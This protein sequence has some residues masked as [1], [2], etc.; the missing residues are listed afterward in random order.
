MRRSRR[1]SCLIGALLAV[2]SGCGKNAPPSAGPVAKPQA[3]AGAGVPAFVSPGR[4]FALPDAAR[5]S[6]VHLEPDGTRRLIV[7]GMRL[8]ERP[9]G[10]IERGE[11]VFPASRV[12]SAR[13]LPERLGGGHLFHASTGS[14]T[15]LWRAKEWT[16]R[17]EPFANV[18][19]DVESIVPGFDRLYVF[20]RRA[21]EVIALDA[22][23]GKATDLGSLPA[24][25]SY[26]SIAVVDDW[27]AAVDVPYQGILAT[28]DAGASWTRV[29]SFP[30]YGV[31]LDAGRLVLA[32]ADGRLVLDAAGRLAPDAPAERARGR[33]GAADDEAPLPP[34]PLGRR[35]LLGAVL[36]GFPDTPDSA[37]V[38]HQ[39]A[40]GR[41]RLRD[42]AVLAVRER[43]LLAAATCQGVPLG[44][45]IGFVCGEERGHTTIY[46]LGPK[47]ELR[48]VL[49]FERPRF[50]AASDTGS[51]VVRGGCATDAEPTR[52]GYCVLDAQLKRR[53]IRMQGDV[54]VERVVALGDGRVAVIV[55]PR[56]GAPGQ[57]TL[58]GADGS[59][60]SKKLK[61]PEAEPS[62]LAL[63]KKGL[64]LDGFVERLPNAKAKG[65]GKK[66]AAAP[67][68][69]ESTGSLL[70][71]WVVAAG[72]FVGV[73][74]ALDGAVTV[75]KVENDIGQSLLSGPL[76]LVLGRAGRGAETTDGGFTWRDVELH[77]SP[78][79]ARAPALSWD[80]RERG[81]TRVGCAFGGWLRVGYRGSDTDDTSEDVESPPPTALPRAAG[82][83]WQLRCAPTGGFVDPPP[84]FSAPAP[85]ARPASRF[86]RFNPVPP[87]ELESADWHGFLGTPPPPRGKQDVGF[88]FGLE[89][90]TTRVRGYVWGPRGASWDRVAN[91][92]FRAFDEMALTDAV[93]STS[94]SRPPF[95]DA[96]AAAQSF[97]RD[98]NMPVSWSASLDAEGRAGAVLINARGSLDLYLI[99][100]NRSPVVVPDVSRHGLYQL[101]GVARV[102]SAWYVGGQQGYNA[103]HLFRVVGSTLVSVR[104][105]PL[106]Q[107]GRSGNSTT[108]T[109]VRTSRADA[110]AVLVQV[111][112]TRGVA[113]SWF[114][115]PIDH[116]SGDAGAPIELSPERLASF[117]PACEAGAS[118]YVLSVEPPVDPYVDFVQGADAVRQ[119]RLTAKLIAGPGSLCTEALAAEADA[120]MVGRFAAA[121]PGAWAGK[122]TVTMVLHDRDR[123][124]RRAG[125]RCAP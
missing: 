47:L 38:I 63:L 43:A 76:A 32:T 81:C 101:G 91:L 58:V 35:P 28:F 48:R 79:T 15:S 110:L 105:Y 31:S 25:A 73:R 51:L 80:D 26:G 75:G 10:A 39:G 37:V 109:L 44:S 107:G 33:E 120:A 34:S 16:G 7:S 57:L 19:V 122:S 88:D 93:W 52:G 18:D 14:S 104:Q 85:A 5:A 123:S 65:D 87:E 9:S 82:G 29:K 111:R 27:L 50:V 124:G 102:G 70:A 99:E 66:G 92:Q 71:G 100:E 68:Q 30:S 89:H 3:R 94:T 4:L 72:P 103:F 90:T 12:V 118:G 36:R 62:T 24:A 64:W 54:G 60:S 112:R 53:E 74:V 78:A 114:V 67:K 13:E 8:L 20:D 115:Y 117:P 121:G 41:V 56:L 6:H 46:A 116:V 95:V 69:G 49:E 11:Q 42:G 97:G 113:T 23:T 45:G 98:P 106:R 125:F 21:G 96:A 61:L 83:R 86:G 55:P 84:R 59:A 1:R 22:E 119:R 2:A 77:T 17:I 40:I 108:S